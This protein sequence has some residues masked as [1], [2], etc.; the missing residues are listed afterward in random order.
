MYPGIGNQRTSQLYSKRE[1]KKANY[2]PVSL[3]NTASKVM[4]SI[5]RDHILDHMQSNNLLSKINFC[6][7]KGRSTVL[8]LLH[9]MKKWT[10]ML[11][12]GNIVD[13]IY[14]DFAKAFAKVPHNRLVGKMSS[15]G[16][17][18]QVFG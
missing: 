6:F 10:D 18:E 15:Y 7:V 17:T 8:Q 16:I 12:E 9:V 13:A 3:T 1:T 11:D 5:V 4:E 2:R 14:M